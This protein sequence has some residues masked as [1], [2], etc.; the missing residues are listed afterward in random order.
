DVVEE[1]AAAGEVVEGQLV[2]HERGD[3]QQGDLVEDLRAADLAAGA[4]DPRRGAREG[5]V[6]G[7]R[8]LGARGEAAA[9]ERA[10]LDP[11]LRAVVDADHDAL[12]ALL[13]LGP[14]GGEVRTGPQEEAEPD[15]EAP[16]AT[17]HRAERSRRGARPRS[18]ARYSDPGAGHRLRLRG[19]GAH[20]LGALDHA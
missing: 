14:E 6:E 20:V 17:I 13:P 12:V 9:K 1:A 11:A 15:E 8:Q 19:D 7:H 5:R 18:G 10:T 2:V 4:H 16:R 3:R